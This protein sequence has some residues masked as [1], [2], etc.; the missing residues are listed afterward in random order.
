M[1]FHRFRQER[2]MYKFGSP[3]KWRK[4]YIRLYCINS[5]ICGSLWLIWIL[6]I[7]VI[8]SGYTYLKEAAYQLNHTRSQEELGFEYL[9][10]KH[11]GTNLTGAE[12][13]FLDLLRM[14]SLEVKQWVYI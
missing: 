8:D 5:T 7:F 13:M 10:G 9:Y 4:I 2:R 6:N 1:N 14:V 11:V 3:V 12:D